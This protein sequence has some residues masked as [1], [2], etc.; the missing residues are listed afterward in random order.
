MYPPPGYYQQLPQKKK[1][2]WP[3]ILGGMFV[4]MLLGIGGCLAFVGGVANEIDKESKRLV[5]VTYEVI[6]SGDSVAISYTGNSKPGNN[7]ISTAQETGATLPWTKVVTVDGF[8]KTATVSATNGSAGG[9]ITCRIKVDDK[10]IS[11]QTST[12]E[13]ATVSCTGIW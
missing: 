11:E 9:E 4:V 6:G 8:V 5:N 3:W 10:V 1:A 13:F 2:K 7:G 12:G